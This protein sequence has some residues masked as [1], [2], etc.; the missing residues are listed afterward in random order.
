MLCNDRFKIRHFID[1]YYFI[2][3]ILIWFILHATKLKRKSMQIINQRDICACEFC[4]DV[5]I[6]Q[7]NKIKSKI[8]MRFFSALGRLHTIRYLFYSCRNSPKWCLHAK[9]LWNRGDPPKKT[10]ISWITL[11]FMAKNSDFRMK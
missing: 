3:N 9:L 6:I 8:E 11:L 5:K 2:W 4:I 7:D 10:S 1:P